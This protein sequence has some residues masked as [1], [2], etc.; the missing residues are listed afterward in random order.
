MS[1]AA[2][3]RARE[4]YGYL[5][6]SK[7]NL[8]YAAFAPEMQKNSSVA[9]LT[10]ASQKLASLGSETKLVSEVFQP[11][12]M[13]AGTSY[14]R[15]SRYTKAKQDVIVNVGIN[16]D[17]QLNAM[18]FGE[19]PALR[20]DPSAEYKTKAKLRLPFKG[21]WM[22]YQGGRTLSENAFA[23]SPDRHAV[24]FVLL[25]DGRPFS[26]TGTTNHD[27]Y[28]FGQPVLAPADGT[29]VQLQ[30]GYPDAQP[31]RPM[32]EI[33]KGNYVVISHGDGE[34]SVLSSLKQGSIRRGRGEKVKAGDVVGSCGNSGTAAIP[35]IEYRLQST[36]GIPEPI[37]L[38]AQFVDY[39]ADGKPV[40]SG[41]PTRGQM[42]AN[43]AAAES[44]KPAQETAKQ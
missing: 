34:F 16:E 20:D 26:G 36:R 10:A 35:H 7:A 22:V 37:S 17:G 32:V 1:A 40:A 12:M 30:N 28:C 31:G 9:R 11:S 29:I 19:L 18:Q 2:K 6:H 33:G 13:G 42:V 25:K 44:A 21:D 3:A 5:V 8:L 24:A 38:P 27:Y 23:A 14:V 15:V 4:L 39:V 41:E 43:A